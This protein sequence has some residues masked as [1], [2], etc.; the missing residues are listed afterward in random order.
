MMSPADFDPLYQ[1]FG[2][3]AEYTPRGGA[4][5]PV[6]IVI[7]RNIGQYGETANITAKTVGISV[8]VSQVTAAPRK[9]DTFVV[10][11]N[12]YTVDVLQLSDEFEHRV[13]AA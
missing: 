7:S 8:R 5:V 3:D 2:A 13:F 1:D 6:R 12:T 10:G 4:A 9:G 11:G